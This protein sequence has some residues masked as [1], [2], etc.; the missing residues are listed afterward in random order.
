[1]TP[2]FVIKMRLDD[3]CPRCHRHGH[4]DHNSKGRLTCKGDEAKP[5][6]WP[7]G[8]FVRNV[9]GSAPGF[10][11]AQAQVISKMWLTNFRTK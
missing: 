2:E 3:W 10:P 9:K 4:Q 8:L 6:S 1:M 5:N 11:T 7:D